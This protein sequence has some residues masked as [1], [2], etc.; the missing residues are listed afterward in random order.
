MEQKPARRSDARASGVLI[1]MSALEHRLL[2]LAARENDTTINEL[3]LA[4]LRPTFIAQLQQEQLDLGLPDQ[5][6]VGA[7]N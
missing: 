6:L 5:N 7:N 4:A 3:V 1:R 2:R